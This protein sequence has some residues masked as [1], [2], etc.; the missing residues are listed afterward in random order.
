MKRAGGSRGTCGGGGRAWLRSIGGGGGDIDDAGVEESMIAMIGI[1]GV[2]L[3]IVFLVGER[4]GGR[5]AAS[6]GWWGWW[7]WWWWRSSSA[8]RWPA[9]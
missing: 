6:P 9:L 5:G 1:A 7:W 3:I 8:P 4:E 2:Y